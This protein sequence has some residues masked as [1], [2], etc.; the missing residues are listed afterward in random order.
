MADQ[1]K[2][3]RAIS[4]TSTTTKIQCFYNTTTNTTTTVIYAIKY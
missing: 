3:I 4:C 2:S 1:A